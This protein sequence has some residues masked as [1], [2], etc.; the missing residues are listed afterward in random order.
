MPQG[1]GETVQPIKE[2]NDRMI[3]LARKNGLNWLQDYGNVLNTMLQLQR[4]G[5]ARWSG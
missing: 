5:A 1:A 2:F 3:E 4:A